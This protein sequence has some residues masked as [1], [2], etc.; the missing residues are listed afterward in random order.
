L[1]IV[2][3]NQVVSIEQLP[4]SVEAFRTLRDEL[5][6]TPHGGAAMMILALLLY[7]GEPQL[8]QACLTV[9]VD[10]DQLVAGPHGYRDRQLRNRDLRRIAE[11]LGAQP[12]LPQAYAGGTSPEN[13]YRLPGPPWSFEFAANPH[14]GDPASGVYKVFVRCSGADSPRPVTLQRNQRGHWKA[15]EWSSLVTGI[16]PPV[17]VD[18]DE[19]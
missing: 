10:G 8:G 12:Y 2:T 14:S 4:D 18:D 6:T 15:R 19:L 17:P 3:E 5:A 13:H 1:S 9:A 16:Q 11:Q 7:S